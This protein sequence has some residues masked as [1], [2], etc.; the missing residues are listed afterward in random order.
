MNDHPIFREF[1]DGKLPRLTMTHLIT[2]EHSAKH[3]RLQHMHEDMLEL[4]YV[5]QGSGEYE[6]GRHAYHVQRGDMIVCNADVLHGEEPT[7]KRKILSYCI[8]LT[9]VALYGLP[10]NYLLPP[11]DYPIISCGRLAGKVGDIMRLLTIFSADLHTLGPICDSLSCGILLMLLEIARSNSKCVPPP[12]IDDA[13]AKRIKT[14]IDR[15]YSEPLSLERIGEALNIS[16]SYLSHVFKKE[17]GEAPMQ[18]LYK[19]RIGEAQSLLID[20]DTSIGEIADRLSYG[21]ITHFNAAFKKHVG[22]TP[23][24]Y[25]KSFKM[26]DVNEKTDN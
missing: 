26:M 9:D 7:A 13:I 24:R 22:M 16:P 12:K 20:T 5:A 23:G 17:Y 25:R 1:R 19:R 4:F 18:Y 21:S 14:Y 2:A 15:N 10:D 6:V 11:D 8:S 3:A